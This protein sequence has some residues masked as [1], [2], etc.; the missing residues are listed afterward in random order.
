[1][2]EEKLREKREEEGKGLRKRM[3]YEETIQVAVAKY[4]TPLL[5]LQDRLNQRHKCLET[6]NKTVD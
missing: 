3:K 6:I 1:M 4:Q 5:T 2:N